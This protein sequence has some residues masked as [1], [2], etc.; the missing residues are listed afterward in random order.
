MTDVVFNGFNAYTQVVMLLGGLFVCGIGALFLADFLHWRMK[1]RLYKGEIIGVRQGKSSQGHGLYYPVI[2]YKNETGEIVRADTSGGSSLLSNKIPGRAVDILVMPNDPYTVRLHRGIPGALIG[3]VFFLPGLF[4]VIQAFRAFDF[5]IYTVLIG[6]AVLGFLGYKFAKVI[7][8]RAEWEDVNNF[9]ARKKE[10]RKARRE[11][12]EIM[13]ADQIRAQLRKNDRTALKTL[14]VLILTG[15]I[16]CGFGFHL[17]LE[18]KYMASEGVS[19]EG[20]VVEMH[21]EYSS[22]SDGG[23]SYVYYPVV[24]FKD[25][26]DQAVIFRDRI[27]SNPASFRI[28]ETVDVLYDPANPGRSFID[29][30]AWN[31]LP[32]VAL[33]VAGMFA[34]WFGVNS[35]LAIRG[36]RLSSPETLPHKDGGHNQGSFL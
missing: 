8:P 30:G 6:A 11:A 3:G 35:L 18:Q 10:E 21:S 24:E 28:G 33:L 22:D 26:N 31:W 4:L 19:T 17:L 1:A 32:S 5:S 27:G 36:R 7:K 23:G 34:L 16:L 9:R 12:M 2:E 13:G 29:R 25:M 15:L 20:R 14:P